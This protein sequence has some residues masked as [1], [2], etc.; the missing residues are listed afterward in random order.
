MEAEDGM[1][2][3]EILQ[4][5][6]KMCDGIKRDINEP[7]KVLIMVDYIKFDVLKLKKLGAME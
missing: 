4:H 7:D 3:D 1:S 6:E 5:I 2:I